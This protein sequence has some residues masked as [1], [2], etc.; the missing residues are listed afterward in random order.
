MGEKR[1]ELS[2]L[3]GVPELLVLRLLARREMYGY[4]VVRAIREAT[5][6]GLE[7]GEG[8][9]YPILHAM[10]KN[11]WVSSRRKVH[12][13]RERIYYRL[14]ERGQGRLKESA[15]RW[16]EISRAIG[17]VMGAADAKPL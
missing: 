12:D 7:F 11:K 14:T 3:N 4:E 5:G 9:I 17:L 2:F 10:E 13:G 15:S 6:G 16:A 8:C 1:D